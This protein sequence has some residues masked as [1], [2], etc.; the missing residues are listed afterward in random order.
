MWNLFQIH[1]FLFSNKFTAIDFELPTHSS[2]SCFSYFS[3]FAIVICLGKTAEKAE[4]RK[5]RMCV[6]NSVYHCTSKKIFLLI[7]HAPQ[8][9]CACRVLVHGP[10][11]KK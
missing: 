6:E 1:I 4:T 9:R 8:L 10:V 5:R 3:C 11:Y 7:I 2:F